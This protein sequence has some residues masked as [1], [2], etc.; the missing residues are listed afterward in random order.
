MLMSFVSFKNGLKLTGQMSWKTA[1]VFLLC[2]SSVSNV[3]KA[4][5]TKELAPNSDDVTALYT[6]NDGQA[7]FAAYDSPAGSRLYIQLDDPANQQ[8]YFGFSQQMTTNNGVDGDYLAAAFYYRVKDP[9]GNVVYGPIAV[10]ASN[11]NANTWTL[12]SGGPAAIDGTGYATS[13]DFNYIPAGGAVGGDYYIEFSLA[14]NSKAANG[15]TPNNY[16]AIKFWDITVATRT[17][18]AAIDGRIWTNRWNLR[19]PSISQGTDPTYTY[20]DRPFNGHIYTYSSDGFVS[21]IDFDN[22]GFRGLSFVLAF[23]S[24]GTINETDLLESRK[25]DNS[26]NTTEGSYQLFIND[27]DNFIYPSGTIGK[28]STE[29]YVREC[30]SRDLCASYAVSLPGQVEIVLDFNSASGAGIYDPGT[31]DVILLE[32]VTPGLGERAPYERCISWDGNDGLGNPVASTSP[33]PMYLTYFQGIVHFPVYDVEYMPT[34][35]VPVLIRP[36]S[37]PGHEVGVRFDDSKIPEDRF[38]GA[39]DVDWTGCV[40]QC[41]SWTNFN[42]GE[43]NTINTWWYGNSVDAATSFI[44]GCPLHALND[45]DTTLQNTTVA[46]DVLLNDTGEFL[47]ASTVSTTGLSGPTNGAITSID[48]MTGAISYL[49]N[50]NFFGLDS[51][52][53]QICENIIN[54]DCDTVWVFI[55]TTCSIV[56]GQNLIT[57]TVFEDGNGDGNLTSGEIGQIGIKVI[58]YEDNNQDGI[59]NGGDIAIDTTQTDGTGSYS[60]NVV[61]A[62][63][64]TI[65]AIN[66]PVGGVAIDAATGCGV[67]PIIQTI[68]VAESIIISDVN[69]GFNAAHTYRSDITVTLTSPAGTTVTVIQG[70]SGGSD[71]DTNYD[72]LLDDTSGNTLDDGNTD[73]TSAPYYDRTA[74]PAN[75]LSAF[76][77]ENAAGN[78]TITICDEY[79]T[80]DTGTYNRSQLEI[81]SAGAEIVYYVV[82][83]DTNSLASGTSFTTDNVE[84]AIFSATGQTDCINNFGIV[85]DADLSLTK[86]TNMATVNVG[87]TVSYTLTLFNDGPSGASS[88]TISDTLDVNLTYVSSTG[89]GTYDTGTHLWSPPTVASGDSAIINILAIVDATGTITNKTEIFASGLNDP[90]ST[91]NNSNASEDDQSS[92]TITGVEAN[93]S[94]NKIVDNATPNVG[95]T[96]TFTLTIANAGPDDATNV[97]VTDLLPTGL[98]YV[99][100][101]G[102]G[103]YTSGT[104]IW[105][106]GT[107]TI[108]TPKTLQIVA[109]VDTVSSAQNIAAITANDL[110]DSDA[111]NNQDTVNLS[112]PY[113][114]LSL[115]KTINLSAIEIGADAIYTIV[116]SNAGPAA[117]EGVIV[118]DTLPSSFIYKSDDGSASHSGGVVTW[119]VGTIGATGSATI[120]ITVTANASGIFTNSAEVTASNTYDPN[121][122]PNNNTAENDIDSTCVSIIVPFCSGDSYTLMAT[123]GLNNYQ[124]YRNGSIISGATSD[125]YTLTTVTASSTDTISYTADDMV[126]G[127]PYKEDC[128][129]IF[130]DASPAITIGSNSPICEGSS[131]NLTESGTEATMWSWSGPDGFNSP[132]QNPSIANA[133]AINAGRYYVTITNSLGCQKIDSVDVVT[134]SCNLPPVADNDTTTTNED[135]AVVLDILTDDTDPDGILSGDSITILTDPLYGTYVDNMDSTLTYT[136]NPNA[137]GLDSL[138]YEI[139]DSG[140]PSLCD[141]AWVFIT[142]N[143]VNDPPVADDELASTSGTTPV[144][145]PITL[146]DTDID[147]LIDSTSIV[148]VDSTSNGAIS[149]DPI[150]GDITYTPD[151]GFSGM[152]TLTYQVCDTG[153]PLPAKCDTAQ[154]IITVSLIPVNLPPVADNDTTSTNEDTAVS[155]N[156]LLDDSDPDGSLIGDSIRILTMPL[157]GAVVDNGDSTLTYDPVANFFGIDSLQYEIC[158]TSA[159]GSLCDTAWVFITINPVNDPP[160]ADDDTTMTNEDTAVSLN[161]L[162]DD[163]DIDGDLIGDSIRILTMPL[164]GAVVDNNDSTLTY[165]PIA[166]FNGIDSLQY[167]ICDTSALGSL[168][169]TAWVFITVNPVNDPPVATDDGIST[170]EDTPVMV[171]VVANDNDNLDPLGNID[172]T[173]VDTISG[174]S[175][176]NGTVSIDPTTGVITYTPNVGYVGLDSLEYV[177]CDDGNPLPAQCD[178]AKVVINVGAVNDPPLAVLDRDTTNEDTPVYV[179]I[180]INDSDPDGDALTTMEVILPPT[181]GTISIADGDSL[182]YTPNADFTGNDTLTYRVCDAG[183]LCD[184]AYVYL[185]IEPVNDPPVADNDTTSTNEDT[186]ISLDILANDTDPDGILSGDSITIL[187]GPMVGTVVNNQ[188]STLTYTPLPNGNTPDSLQYEICD[189]GSPSLCDT[190]WVYFD[191]TPVNDAPIAMDDATSTPEDTPVTVNVVNNDDDP[192]D[193]SGNIDPTSVDTIP[194]LGPLNGTITINPVTGEITYTPNSG[195][196]GL[197]SLEYVVCD[198]GNPLPAQCDTAKVVINVGAVNDLPLAV[199]DRDTTNE[200]TPVYVAVQI[201][202]SDPDG[203]ALTTMEVILQPTDGTISIADGDSLLYTPNADFTGNDTLTYRVCDAGGL[204]DT[205]YVYLVI[206]PVNDAPIADNDSITGNENNL[207]I[208]NTLLNDVDLDGNLDGDSIL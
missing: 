133:M 196:T 7:N 84:A 56:P 26:V 204:C 106:I 164:N 66:E 36:N 43:T 67:A 21:E 94:I 193:S 116:V 64:T 203:G 53:Y 191:I 98:N 154:V 205:A 3:I 199:L 5:G 208:V 4:E 65:I 50:P 8:I 81:T 142:V 171:N 188:D 91:P 161:A 156:A 99:S 102:G 93:L 62:F 140:S 131:I 146:G 169:D 166:D 187:F 59:I 60:S 165:T 150:T 177:V 124:W 183:G 123:A 31:E 97:V 92:V 176:V 189:T 34:G 96:V 119:N 20:Y 175:P 18:P 159:L 182:L 2:F 111:T 33:V 113:A 167:E 76:N 1:L 143:P 61:P 201:N 77:G 89:D 162:L 79:T 10:D 54:P 11:A 9:N 88:V 172:P 71:G 198:D 68:T 44:P 197:D 137:N 46:V 52:Q 14:P 41:H 151:G 6:N 103:D 22:S 134:M 13:T 42:F 86:T 173:S 168:C 139:C 17:V 121:S 107:V 45:Y 117:A 110:S 128:P 158:D 40:P 47:D 63:P 85:T 101:N 144:L 122:T 108:S 112:I 136:P 192:N 153:T 39:Q 207:L 48:A 82:E 157:N 138:R 19:T 186:P 80:S 90:D 57:G 163:Y 145:I 30:P 58:I 184:T 73:A 141:S 29:P 70:D 37:S 185:V 170:P 200:D 38:V 190:A 55:E 178:T 126:T 23:N 78:W 147:G 206:E 174:G 104:G 127:C 149:I 109:E 24:F 152:D 125:N 74:A 83:V 87:D 12:A 72:V 49:P 16:L 95:D 135:M 35:F 195:Y 194:G 15:T 27:P 32:L 28:I 51:F 179:D 114:D 132:L 69:F 155:L 25:S 130:T 105:N 202:D 129:A 148:L 75:P 118:T 180:Q 115:A 181:D 120:N 160:V 100:D